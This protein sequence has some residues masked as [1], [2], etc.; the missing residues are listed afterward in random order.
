M[1]A[2]WI[3]APSS[4]H[5]PVFLDMVPQSQV[6]PIMQRRRWKVPA[7]RPSMGCQREPLATR[8]SWNAGGQVPD[9][10]M[11][12]KERATNAEAQWARRRR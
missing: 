1:R 12:V 10:G 8:W 6:E 11:A 7:P 5:S 4:P 2:P 9:L 3:A